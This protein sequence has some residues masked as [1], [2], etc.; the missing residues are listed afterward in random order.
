MAD[1]GHVD[2]EPERRVSLG[3]TL[4]KRWR[5]RGVHRAG[6]LAA[7]GPDGARRQKVGQ[8]IDVRN[9]RL[10]F[11][12]PWPGRLP[13]KASTVFSDSMRATKPRWLIVFSTC[14]AAL[15]SC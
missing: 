2:I 5:E 7:A 9:G 4:S 8:V 14:L 12:V 11:C 6:C 10:K 15:S 3:D 13:R 1:I